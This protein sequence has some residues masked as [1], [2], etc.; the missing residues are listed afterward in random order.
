MAAIDELRRNDVD[1]AVAVYRR[2]VADG[3]WTP[4]Q[5]EML[6]M[7]Q[8]DPARLA[9]ELARLASKKS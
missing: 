7:L 3:T 9:A 8:D 6:L 2:A 5:A 4:E 1:G